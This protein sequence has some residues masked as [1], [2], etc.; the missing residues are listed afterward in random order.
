MGCCSRSSSPSRAAQARGC[1]SAEPEFRSAAWLAPPAHA[2]VDYQIG[3]AYPPADA[4]RILVRDRSE[5]PVPGRYNVCYVNGFQTQP[6]E[7]RWW[8]AHHPDLLLRHSGRVVEDPD[9]PGERLLD[10]SAFRQACA[11]RGATIT[12][13]LRDRDVAPAGAPA[14][15]NERC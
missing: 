1:G 14:Y 10:T 5:P 13:L 11:E 7:N 15:H 3:G 12:V 2:V 4:A 9:W 6:D 8:E